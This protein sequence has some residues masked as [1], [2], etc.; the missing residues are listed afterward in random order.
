MK[1]RFSQDMIDAS[2]KALNDASAN[3]WEIKEGKL[4]TELRFPNFVSAF[5]FMTQVAIIAE[6]L[7]HHPE[8]SNV[9]N[10][11]QIYLTTHDVSGISKLDFELAHEITK[12]I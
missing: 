11:V 5:G 1:E 12:L 7:N 2:L 8:W 4:Y 10:K 6:K 9:Y 3:A